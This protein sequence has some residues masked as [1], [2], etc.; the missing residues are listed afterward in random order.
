M[1]LKVTIVSGKQ[2]M[3]QNGKNDAEFKEFHSYYSMGKYVESLHQKGAISSKRYN[4]LNEIVS[5]HSAE[6]NMRGGKF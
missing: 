2:L 3:I 5:R 6:L 1:A 4:H